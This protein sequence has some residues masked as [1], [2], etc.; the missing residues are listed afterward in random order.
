[1]KKLLL[2][3]I[4]SAAALMGC[5]D[6][7]TSNNN[8]NNNNNPAQGTLGGECYPNGTCNEGLECDENNVCIEEILNQGKEGGPCYEDDT[9]DDPLVC[10]NDICRTAGGENG[11]C[12][13]DDTCTGEL[14][15]IVD[16]C[17]VTGETDTPCRL[18]GSCGAQ[19]VCEEGTCRTDLDEDGYSPAHDCDDNDNA[20]VPDAIVECQSE[21]NLGVK[22][23]NA[24]GTWSH[25]TANEECECTTPGEMRE[26][27]CGNCGWAYQRC[28]TDF[29]WELP[30]ECQEEGECASGSEETENCGLC[31]TRTRMCGPTC[32][33]FDWSACTG[34]GVCEAGLVE[35]TTDDCTPLGYI[36]ERECDGSCQWIDSGTCFGDCPDQPRLNGTWPDGTNDFKEEVCIPA[37]AFYMGSTDY[38]GEDSRPQQV[39]HLSQFM[40]D[41]YEVT[42]RRYKECVDSGICTPPVNNISTTNYYQTG[43]DNYPVSGVTWIQAVQFCEWDGGRIL[44]SEA[45]WE[46]AA[47]GPFPRQNKWPWG[48]EFP[49]CTQASLSFCPDN[50]ISEVDNFPDS[51]SYYGIFRMADNVGELARDCFDYNYY[52]YIEPLNPVCSNICTSHSNRGMPFNYNPTFAGTVSN[53]FRNN[54]NSGY[55]INYGF[56]CSRNYM[57]GGL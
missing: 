14:E 48:D 33:W 30:M 19:L 34:E 42:N 36:R 28:G 1:M 22:V 47:R 9:C 41:K 56:R 23:C 53:T 15:C 4:L 31:G 24:D 43:Y 27:D 49:T 21:C 25:C 26:V 16:T 45:E 29:M 51:T 11:P 40:L 7:S 5:D 2:I 3:T 10:F 18:D 55:Y 17:T 8:N 12:F 37:G 44:P 38:G 50:A 32:E 20:V 35:Y 54:I 13:E 52:S 39:I 46:K 57:V 6:D